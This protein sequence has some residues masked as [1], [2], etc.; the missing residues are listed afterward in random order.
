MLPELDTLEEITAA[1][2]WQIP[3]RFNIGISCCDE[4]AEKTPDRIALRRWNRGAPSTDTS[5]GELKVQSD[6]FAAFLLAQGVKPGDRVAIIL[7]QC[8]ESVVT[9]L[10]I[11]KAGMIAVPLARLFAADALEYRLNRAGVSVI[12]TNR[13]G[14]EKISAIHASL[15]DLRQVICTDSFEY[16]NIEADLPFPVWLFEQAIKQGSGENF[17]PE[18]TRPDTPALIIFTSGTTGPP[19]GALHGHGVL[20]GHIPGVQEHHEFMPKPGDLAWTPADWAWAGG[21]L[22]ILLPCLYLGVPVAYGG[23]DR[24][25]PELAFELMQDMAVA[26]AFIPPTA[27][28]LMKTVENP[29]KRFDLNLRTIGSG[30]ESLGKETLSWAQSELGLVVNEF[31]GQTECNLVL[32]SCHAIGVLRP[33]AIGKPVPGHIV[34]VVRPDGS[35]CDIGQR[36]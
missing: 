35:L 16:E 33:G 18:E 10:A 23:I 32:S 36:G 30:G 15:K 1:F 5:Y 9:H 4:W 17:V 31:Y 11:Y 20:L 27:L 12:V 19:K 26:N 22:N 7:P 25:D 8:E 2:E 3:S 14:L 28:R 34:G 21:L 13:D 29:G 24:F 6:A